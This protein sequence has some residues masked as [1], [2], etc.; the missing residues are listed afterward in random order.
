MKRRNC[1]C[2][3]RSQG[4]G[5]FTLIELLVVV[6]II[7][8]LAALLMPALKSARDSARAA[9]CVNN[10]RQV[11][12]ALIQYEIEYEHYL[13]A[14]GFTQ[15][16]NPPSGTET[17]WPVCLARH[18]PKLLPNKAY[19][20]FQWGTP[21]SPNAPATVWQCPSNALRIDV[22]AAPYGGWS[23][24]NYALNTYLGRQNSFDPGSY[25]V[26]STHIGVP[27]RVMMVVETFYIAAPP[28]AGLPS[29]GNYHF[30]RVLPGNSEN[31]NANVHRGRGNI[32]FVDGHIESTTP[33]N[34]EAQAGSLNWLY[35]G[36]NNN[37][38]GP[39]RNRWLD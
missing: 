37:Q 17:I 7:S 2:A 27:E 38:S 14:Y 36:R 34:L 4:Q 8:I 24:P 33:A 13:P 39:T 19:E 30:D 6:A 22:R 5:A 16:D 29:K 25:Y 15:P 18:Y 9:A 1:P 31:P 11:V 12:Q 23:S 26:S 32:G 10:M 20:D 35:A 3:S 28:A 21:D